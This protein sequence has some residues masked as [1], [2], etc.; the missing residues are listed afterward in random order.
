MRKLFALLMGLMIS[1]TAFAEPSGD[2]QTIS[3]EF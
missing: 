3:I 1:T 2:F